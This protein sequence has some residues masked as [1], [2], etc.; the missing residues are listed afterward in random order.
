MISVYM[1]IYIYIYIYI[2][3]Y[4]Y[5]YTYIYIYI[6]IHTHRLCRERAVV[7]GAASGRRRLGALRFSPGV[8]AF[9][10]LTAVVDEK[11]AINY[12][13]YGN[14]QKAAKSS[15]NRP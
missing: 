4:I 13:D 3:I 11:Q 15:K 1:C 8:G 5:I 14:I 9:S 2:H 10:Y 12:Y 6:Y 7:S